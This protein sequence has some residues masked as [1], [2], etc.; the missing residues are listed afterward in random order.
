MLLVC[1]RKSN[2][3]VPNSPPQ[4]GSMSP[5]QLSSAVLPTECIAAVAFEFESPCFKRGCPN[6]VLICC[7][8]LAV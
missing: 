7:S 3:R 6:R 5:T 8:S 4:G 2:L 1:T